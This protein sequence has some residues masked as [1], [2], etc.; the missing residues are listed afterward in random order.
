MAFRVVYTGVDE[1]FVA[2]GIDFE[3]TFAQRPSDASLHE[4]TKITNTA[5]YEYTF[6][7]KDEEGRDVPVTDGRAS[8]TVEATLPLIESI[9]IPVSLTVKPEG[10][11][12]TYAPNSDVTFVVTAKNESQTDNFREPIL[13]F[14]LPVGTTL[15]DFVEGDSQFVIMRMWE[16]EDGNTVGTPLTPD[17]FS[18]D[19][20]KATRVGSGGE[21]IEL[22]QDTQKVTMTFPDVEL[23][24]GERIVIRFSA[25]I[26]PNSQADTC[27]VPRS[28]E[29]P[30]RFPSP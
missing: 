14:D 27:G 13:S 4:I 12:T 6:V 19:T 24:P 10:T 16:D 30:M 25:H 18:I 2:N 15:N 1:H 7:Q 28:W 21:L 20:V 23:K 26:D 8:N 9:R 29:A 5:A 17:L 11:Q 3:V 22:E